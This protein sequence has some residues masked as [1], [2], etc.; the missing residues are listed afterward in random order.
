MLGALVPVTAALIRGAAHE[1]NAPRNKAHGQ[2]RL[3]FIGLRERCLLC[4]QGLAEV[5]TQ[6]NP[7]K[8]YEARADEKAG[9]F[10][11]AGSERNRGAIRGEKALSGGIGPFP[12]QRPGH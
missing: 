2:A 5:E 1:I 8:A 3:V 10:V 12:W 11:F 9:P 4:R 7:Q 6:D